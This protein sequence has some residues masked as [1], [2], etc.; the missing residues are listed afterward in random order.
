M[1]PAIYWL[2]FYH[3]SVRSSQQMWSVCCV[4]EVAYKLWWQNISTLVI[5][6]WVKSTVLLFSSCRKRWEGL[7]HISELRR[8]GRVANVADVV[9]KGQRVKIKVLS[10]TGSKTS[11]SMKVR[12]TENKQPKLSSQLWAEFSIFSIVILDVHVLTGST[13]CPCVNVNVKTVFLL[14]LPGCGP[15]DRRGPE[16]QQEEKRRPRRRW[17]DLYEEPRPAKQPEPG[18]RPRAGAGRHPG[19]KEAHQNFW[20]RE[21]G[22]QTGGCIK[23]RFL[24]KALKVF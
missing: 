10:F 9:S 6:K 2:L 22:D 20:P 5:S 7:V 23:K 15:G 1:V 8:E 14:S 18:P 3:C 4:H 11:L 19:A 21:V 17:G 12:R 16:P 24:F 13:F